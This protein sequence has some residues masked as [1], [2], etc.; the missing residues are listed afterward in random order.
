MIVMMMMDNENIIIVMIVMMDSD[1]DCIIIVMIMMI[2]DDDHGDVS[3][4][5]LTFLEAL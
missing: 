5:L 2:D 1:T 4:Q 3:L